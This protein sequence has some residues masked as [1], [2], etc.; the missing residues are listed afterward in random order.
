MGA[1]KHTGGGG[2]VLEKT[3]LVKE[4]AGREGGHE[5]TKLSPLTARGNF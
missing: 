5:G 4:D 1:S 2:G 3:A